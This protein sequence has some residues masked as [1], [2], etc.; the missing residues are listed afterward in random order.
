[1]EQNNQEGLLSIC[2]RKDDIFVKINFNY[3]LKYLKEIHEHVLA[4]QLLMGISLLVAY[5]LF[6]LDNKNQIFNWDIFFQ[7][8]MVMIGCIIA[9]TIVMLLISYFQLIKLFSV[10]YVTKVDAFICVVFLGGLLSLVLHSILGFS[11]YNIIIYIEVILIFVFGLM[12][13]VRLRVWN[14]TIDATQ[15]DILN[16]FDLKAIYEN[17]FEVEDG[18]PILLKETEVN[19]DLLGRTAVVENLYSSILACRTRNHSHVI[20]LEGKWGSGKSTI[21]NI[22]KDKIRSNNEE[23]AN[24]KTNQ[25][26]SQFVIVDDFDP[27]LIGSV[28]MLFT[29]LYDALLRAAGVNMRAEQRRI[30]RIL[31]NTLKIVRECNSDFNNI[32]RVVEMFR[33]AGETN[34]SIESIKKELAYLLEKNNT[35][36]VIVIDNLERSEPKNIL[37]LFKFLGTVLNLQ[38]IVFVLVYS[39]EQLE[40]IMSHGEYNIEPLYFE[41]IINEEISVPAINFVQHWR[42]FDQSIKN[43]MVKYG[44]TE[45]EILDCKKLRTVLSYHVKDLRQFIRYINSV[46]PVVI[47]PKLHLDKPTLLIIETIK[48]MDIE[49]HEEVLE[50]SVYFIN[51]DLYSINPKEISNI[52]E[53]YSDIL[54]NDRKEIF[55]KLESKHKDFFYLLEDIFPCLGEKTI[56]DGPSEYKNPIE[57]EKFFYAYFLYGDNEFTIIKK[58]V[59]DVMIKFND[60]DKL[61]SMCDEEKNNH[62]TQFIRNTFEIILND[63]TNDQELWIEELYFRVKADGIPKQAYILLAQN[64]CICLLENNVVC[65]K[66]YWTRKSV[67]LLLEM[68]F[69]IY[70]YLSDD[71]ADRLLQVLPK[72]CLTMPLVYKLYQKCNMKNI[73]VSTSGNRKVVLLKKYFD[74]LCAQILKYKTDIFTRETYTIWNYKALSFYLKQNNQSNWTDQIVNYLISIVK[75]DNIFLIMNEF[76]QR[77]TTENNGRITYEYRLSLGDESNVDNSDNEINTEDI[78][79]DLL[80]DESFK[81]ILGTG[82]QNDGFKK[83]IYD[84]CQEKID[85]KTD[86]NRIKKEKYDER[87]LWR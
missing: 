51:Q 63:N 86:C 35:T 28:E 78:I 45:A 14:P 44:M 60:I 73:S 24:T 68:L 4:W 21:I 59:L 75:L 23:A 39:K 17:D 9:I 30:N 40:N 62:Y 27:W 12:V 8:K 33:F 49:L 32:H 82:S 76:V 37:A 29:S 2:T 36:Y 5:M 64:I 56:Y 74:E 87:D 13:L 84:L 6:F 52:R 1:M 81:R 11:N 16:K 47:N 80:A 34:L 42:I 10:K 65:K 48:F 72:D 19:Y 3:I 54:K 58:Y 66:P 43:I 46:L 69:Y 31:L 83:I 61:N 38:N 20:G 79:H 55:E 53:K 26:I 57:S 18:K 22:V 50:N 25:S 70:N 41:K 71:E 7:N 85:G 67:D 15:V 77:S